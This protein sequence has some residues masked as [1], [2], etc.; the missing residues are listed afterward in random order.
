M[1]RKMWE[2][3][4]ISEWPDWPCPT[5]RTGTLKSVKDLHRYEDTAEWKR[6]QY[7]RNPYDLSQRFSWWFRCNRANCR[8]P[9][10]VIGEEGVSPEFDDDGTDYPVTYYRPLA[11]DP[12]PPL[13]IPPKRCPEDVQAE[14]V[15]AFALFLRDPTAAGNALR[16]AVE[17]I[18]DHKQVPRTVI[19]KKQKRVRINLHDRIVMFK[20]ANAEAAEALMAVKWIGNEGSHAG[21]LSRSDVLDAMDMIENVIDKFWGEKDQTLQRL[22]ARVN[23]SKKPRSKLRKRKQKK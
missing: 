3:E 8:E 9:A 21:S 1:N 2:N 6:T 15:R 17:R 22:I 11:I 4:W 12:S 7:D 16:G 10:V 19:S 5:C 23:K 18:L 13:F 14:L 20:A